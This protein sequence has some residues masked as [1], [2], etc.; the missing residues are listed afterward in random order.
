MAS[1]RKL[2][3][4]YRMELGEIQPH[5]QEAEAVRWIFRQY[6]AG[7]SYSALAG[8]LQDQGLPYDGDKPWNKN[9]VARILENGKYAGGAG[10]PPILTA[11]ILTAAQ[12]QRAERTSPSQKT[13]A[14]KEL[15]RLCGGNPPKYVEGQVLG[16][17]NRLIQNPEM[18]RSPEES[19]Q[20]SSEIQRLRRELDGT[21]HSP[22]ID[23]EQA[24]KAS[25]H[26]AA[27][28]LNCIGS[29]EYETQR[30]R[31]LFQSYQPMTALD[32]DILRRSVW[33]ITYRGKTTEI[34]LKNG[35]MIKEE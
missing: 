21:L 28:C 1:N 33:R 2:P 15:R 17:L 16:A 10:Y 32:K 11:E 13:P 7:V 30:L 22:P 25:F 4:G 12:A 5:P 18:I 14:Q 29:G 27:L 35:Q 19:A 23:E 26:L 9:M 20:D 8:S 34:P 31:R 6:L 24:R 3:F